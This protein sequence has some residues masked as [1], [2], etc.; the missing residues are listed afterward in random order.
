MIF[1]N[2]VLR[3]K[4]KCKRFF[5]FFFFKRNKNC[6]L[7]INFIKLTMAQVEFKAEKFCEL[8][9][10]WQK[11]LHTFLIVLNF[12]GILD[13]TIFLIIA[14]S[15]VSSEMTCMLEWPQEMAC[16]LEFL[17]KELKSLI[18]DRYCNIHPIATSFESWF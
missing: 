5:L 11:K 6:L 15:L 10:N 3:H 13:F 12:R 16:M 17:W 14:S 4:M 1:S 8:F 18:K 9:Q 7:L 2:N